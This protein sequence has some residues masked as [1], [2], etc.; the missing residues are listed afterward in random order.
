MS[1]HSFVLE[2][3]GREER[4][5]ERGVREPRFEDLVRDYG[6]RAFQFAYHLCGNI[7]EA[8]DVTQESFYRALRGWDSYDPAQPLDSWFFTILRHV[9]LD[10]RKR[11]ER[12]HVVSIDAPVSGEDGETSHADFVRDGEPAV[13]EV[14]ERRETADSVRRALGELG[15]EHR[16]VLTLCDMQHMSY[17]EISKILDVPIG[18]VRS[19]LSRAREALRDR[20]AAVLG[21]EG[22]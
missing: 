7:D 8:K 2:R 21:E 12:R 17:E 1:G 13:L 16:A 11:Y 9:F 4:P 19:R 18:T 6:E 22:A 3:P 5:V 14:L 10:G 15:Y 20:L